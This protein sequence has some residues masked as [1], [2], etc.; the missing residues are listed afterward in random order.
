MWINLCK[1]KI[2]HS[3]KLFPWL[4]LCF[5]FFVLAPH[6]FDWCLVCI[7]YSPDLYFIYLYIFLSS[8]SS[9][10]PLK[11]VFVF[12]GDQNTNFSSLNLLFFFSVFPKKPNWNWSSGKCQ[13][14]LI[15]ESWSKMRNSCCSGPLKYKIFFFFCQVI[16][17]WIFVLFKDV[18]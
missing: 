3:T 17:R 11:R 9:K 6:H 5:V 14:Q 4:K 13:L 8:D 16:V 7:S 15:K 2:V 18:M 1:C 10:S 12:V